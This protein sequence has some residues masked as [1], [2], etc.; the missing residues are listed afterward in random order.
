MRK[1]A[2]FD[3]DGTLT[4]KDTF[5]EFVKFA[6]GALH[7][8]IGFL[9][10]SPILI[11]MKLHLFPNWK[12]KQMVF[13]WFLKGMDYTRFAELGRSF[14]TKVESMKNERT[15]EEL[16]RLKAE[17]ADVYVISASI[18]E[19]V[20]PYCESLGVKDV[21]ATKIEVADGKLTGRFLS[22]NCYGHE[23]VNRLLEAEPNRNEYYLYAFGD[24]RG[25]KEMLAFADKACLVK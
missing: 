23:K 4:T 10:Y 18:E 6:C 5:L 25:D 8:Y 13:S 9:F 12:S 17:G 14:A 7:F 24:S 1:V 20:H 2:V 15:H 3:F 16:H 11:L 19:W 22:K 21:L